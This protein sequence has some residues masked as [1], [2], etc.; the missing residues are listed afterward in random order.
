MSSV[1]SSEFAF[2]DISKELDSGFLGSKSN[3][4]EKS[5]TA[6]VGL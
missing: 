2:T 1:T 6:V 5:R 3:V 4:P